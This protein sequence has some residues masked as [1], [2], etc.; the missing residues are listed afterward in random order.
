MITINFFASIIVLLCAVSQTETA[1]ATS[2]KALCL[3]CTQN[4]PATQCKRV[5]QPWPGAFPYCCI[6]TG[7]NMSEIQDSLHTPTCKS[8]VTNQTFT[9]HYA[10]GYPPSECPEK[11]T[12]LHHEE[13]HQLL[14]L[15][16][17]TVTTTTKAAKRTTKKRR[18]AK[19][20][21]KVEKKN[22]TTTMPANVTTVTK[23]MVETTKNGTEIKN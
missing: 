5:H 11:V 19:T 14:G 8:S 4:E 13:Q 23:P 18:R 16:A 21:K 2:F 12:P 17:T 22:R 10:C 15:P 6:P 7:M 9:I 20:T 3:C 1:C